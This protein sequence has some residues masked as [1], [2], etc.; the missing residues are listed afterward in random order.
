MTESPLV[1][2]SFAVPVFSPGD[3]PIACLNKAMAF[4]I[5]VASSRF[6][7]TNNQLRN[8]SN[9]RNHATIQ[10]GKVTVQQVQGRQ[11]QSYYGTG[12][13]SNATSSRGNNASRQAKVVKCYN[14]QGEGHMARQCI[15]LKR[16]RNAAWYK[17]KA[18]LVEAH[19][20]GII[21]DEEQ[22]AF[23]ADPGVPDG[24]AVQ[25]IIPNNAAFQTKDLDT[26][27]SDCDDI[28][29]AQ[30]VLMAN[31]SNYGSDVISE[32]NK[33]IL[34]DYGSRTVYSFVKSNSTTATCP[35][36]LSTK[37]TGGRDEWND[38]WETAWLPED[39]SAKNRAPWE[40][41]VNFSISDSPPK[42]EEV[43]DPDTWPIIGSKGGK[44]LGL[45][46]AKEKKKKLKQDGK[47]LYSLEN[48]KRDYRVMKQ[49]VH[50]GLW[51]KEI[52][53]MEEAKLGGSA[54][55]ADDLDRFL[56]TAS[57]LKAS[58]SGPS[59]MEI[60]V[61][62]TFGFGTCAATIHRH[63]SAI[64]FDHEIFESGSSDLN[65]SKVKDSWDLKNKPDGWET[66]SKGEEDGNIWEMSQREEDILVQEYER[67]IAFSKFQ[68]IPPV[69][70]NSEESEVDELGESV[71]PSSL[72]SLSGNVISCY[73]SEDWISRRYV[74]S[75]CTIALNVVSWETD[76][77][78]VL[79]EAMNNTQ[80]PPT[81]TTVVNTTGAPVTNTVAN[82]AEKPE[83]FNGQKFKSKL[84][85]AQAVQ[86]VEAWKH[87]DFL[88]HNY[89]LN[90]LLRMERLNLGNS[91]TANI[92]GKGDAILASSS[93]VPSVLEFLQRRKLEAKKEVATLE[94]LHLNHSLSHRPVSVKLD[95]SKPD[96]SKASSAGGKL[97]I[98]KP[99]CE[100]NGITLTPKESLS[101]TS[102]SK[103]PNSP[104]T[105][106]NEESYKFPIAVQQS[107]NSL[108]SQDVRGDPDSGIG[109]HWRS[110]DSGL[111]KFI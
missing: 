42:E 35:R 71:L 66:T 56:D 34:A 61:E 36:C 110:S 104:F 106:K 38:T 13:K 54:G 53:K 50:A 79:R 10:D 7:S 49:R 107:F 14:C 90:G 98:L 1:D 86:A 43:L 76:G 59:T 93:E 30:V 33:L 67:R 92:K 32:I 11:G 3:D 9:P 55:A 51:V 100:R 45:V 6:P 58:G 52:E 95:I 40:T 72:L 109:G 16:L 77:E 68:H 2:S 26:Y 37:A 63:D 96:I 89:V 22:L 5:A 65:N 85:N 31:I 64:L 27:D 39:L 29:N 81:A 99:S 97:H 28:S 4:L 83:K 105:G 47:S 48:V 18:M 62:G 73:H 88:C 41:D 15:N 78:S 17:D 21:L 111:Y 102:G 108:W 46:T 80:T 75:G 84:S 87:S 8:S 57:D 20:D 24:Q 44:R 12:Y 91:P 101:P 19:K 103:V 23:L 70:S 74:K 82:H 69:M 25:S 94:F 60:L